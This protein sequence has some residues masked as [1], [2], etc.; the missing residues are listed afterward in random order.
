MAEKPGVSTAD[1][2]LGPYD[3]IA[4]VQAADTEAIAK[5]VLDEI[6]ILDGVTHTTTCLVVSKRNQEM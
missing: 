2:M 4:F 5:M 3:V 1:V 6:G